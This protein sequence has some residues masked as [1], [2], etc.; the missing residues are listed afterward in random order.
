MEADYKIYI[1]SGNPT[2]LVKGLRDRNEKKQLNDYLLDKYIFAEQVGFISEDK[3]HLEMAGGEFCG[4]ATRCAIY[5]YLDGKDGNIT[6]KVNDITLDGGIE[7]GNVW[8]TMPIHK[9]PASDSVT[10]IDP[11]TIIRMDGITHVVVEKAMPDKDEQTAKDAAYEIMKSLDL[12]GEPACGVM[13][14]HYEDGVIDLTP[15]VYV[16]D[17]NTFFYETACGSG[18]TAVGIYNSVVNSCGTDLNVMQP[19][20]EIIHVNVSYINGVI[21]K[22]VISGKVLEY[23]Y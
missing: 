10:V 1:P 14:I 5:H 6:I 17:I 12:F 16:R 2:I 20:G 3:Y 9:G 19:S 4:N 8:V 21:E 13:F 18:T 7:G 22:A 11:Y 15:V 23:E